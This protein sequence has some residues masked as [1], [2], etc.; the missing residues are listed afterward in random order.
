MKQLQHQQMNFDTAERQARYVKQQEEQNGG[1][2]LVFAAAFLRGMRDIGYKSPAWALCEMIDNC[3]QAQA[4]TIEVLFGELV[5]G[6]GGKQ[7]RQLAVVDDGVGMVPKMISYA[8]RWGGTDREND[9]RG[10]GRYGY[11]LPSSAVSMA[12][13]YSVY[14]RSNGGDWHRVTIDIESLAE[15]AGDSKAINE[16]LEPVPAAPPKWVT[17]AATRVDLSEMETGTVVVLEDLDRL[18]EQAGWKTVKSIKAKCLEQ[19]GVIYRRQLGAVRIFVEGDLADAIDPLFLME[20]GRFFDETEVMAEAVEARTFKVQAQQG[21]TEG[22]VTIRASYLPPNFQLIDPTA[23][24][25]RGKKNKRFKVMK[26]NNGL[27]ICRD[28]RE[29]ECISPPSDWSTWGNY[30]RNVKIEIDFTPDLDEFFGITTAKQQITIKEDMWDRLQNKGKLKE[31]ISD[32]RRRFK[33]DTDALSA[34]T[35]EQE[36]EDRERPSESA[37]RDSEKFKA[38]QRP[39]SERKKKTAEEKLSREAKRRAEVEHRSPEEVAAELVEAATARP[40]QVSYTTVEEG[41]FYRPERMGE[42]R[43][44]YINT[45][46]PFYEKVYNAVP[47]ARSALEVLLFVLAEG[48]LDA[49]GEAETFYKVAR[50]SWSERLHHAL[51]QLSPDEAVQDASSAALELEEA[52]TQDPGGES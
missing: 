24:G 28:G 47:A 13:K 10:F 46:H 32:L 27:H 45:S 52:S 9:R 48:E 36:A 35:E 50:R 21:E 43:R 23:S 12:K 38:S 44:L 5:S 17:K 7:P 16:L 37:M 11:G 34:Q 39:P 2:G 51:E 29:I 3:V 14:S 41:P 8:V 42:Q 20:H 6:Q 19:F 18:G 4:T 15:I 40:F 30:D 31:L 49:E 33:R 26:A 25:K 1:L 22:A